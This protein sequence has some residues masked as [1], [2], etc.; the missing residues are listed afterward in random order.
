M[1][2]RSNNATRV[3]NKLILC[4]AYC[5]HSLNLRLHAYEEDDSRQALSLWNYVG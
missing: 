4:E 3:S 5:E 1:Y 2:Y